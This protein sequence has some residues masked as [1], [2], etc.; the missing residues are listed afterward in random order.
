MTPTRIK[1]CGITSLRDALDA[2]SCGVDALGFVLHPGSPR[3]V[4]PSVA[5]DIIRRLPAFVTSVVL[6]VDADKGRIKDIVNRLHP[7]LLQF[8]GHEQPGDCEA[9]G[10]PYIKAVRATSAN[11]IVEM[12]GRFTGARCILLDSFANE[13]FAN[14]SVADESV[15]GDDFG[16]SGK[17]FDW[18]ITP[19]L[20][21]PLILAGGLNAGNV[22]DAIA[23][24]KP[25][26][27]DVSSGV[28]K[29]KGVK[30]MGKMKAFVEAVR[31]ADLNDG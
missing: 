20:A 26:A 3:Y 5:A 14:G 12:A 28:E 13:S 25:Y 30:D 2:V 4:E 27:V 15:A 31:R 21:K 17:T 11:D 24:V 29:S 23:Q 8:H 10:R 16:G 1:F 22:G 19:S 7:D 9:V 18:R 6:M